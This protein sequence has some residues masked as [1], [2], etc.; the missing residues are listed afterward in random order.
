MLHCRCC[1]SSACSQQARQARLV[2][3]ACMFGGMMLQELCPC[4]IIL[5]VLCVAAVGYLWRFLVVVTGGID[6][7]FDVADPLPFLGLHFVQVRACALWVCKSRPAAVRTTLTPPDLLSML[8]LQMP[9][10][11]L[12]NIMRGNP[13]TKVDVN[14]GKVAQLYG[15]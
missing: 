4:L 12:N 15:D 3:A 1:T 6:A 7:V 10:L 14:I 8:L 9:M 5:A 11:L 2:A 13:W